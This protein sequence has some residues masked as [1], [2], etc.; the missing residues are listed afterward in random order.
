[1][2]RYN[3]FIVAAVLAT[4]AAL[5]SIYGSGSELVTIIIAVA[6]ALGVYQT[7]NKQ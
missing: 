3:K 5:N 2:Q 4:V 7:P 1:M 6:T